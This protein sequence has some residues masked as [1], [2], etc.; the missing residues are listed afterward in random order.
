MRYLFLI[1]VL[2][3]TL[4]A[5]GPP[6]PVVHLAGFVSDPAGTTHRGVWWNDGTPILLEMPEHITKT[7][8]IGIHASNGTILISGSASDERYGTGS[9]YPIVWENGKATILPILPGHENEAGIAMGAVI[10]GGSR[11]T[12][13]VVGN[14][15]VGIPVYWNGASLNILPFQ[16]QHGAG[17]KAIYDTPETMYAAGFTFTDS[18]IAKPC[19]WRVSDSTDMAGPEV[20]DSD[21]D[22]DT[23]VLAL[24]VDE[25]GVVYAAGVQYDED[26]REPVYWV[27]GKRIV[28]PGVTGELSGITVAGGQVIVTG[29]E[30][31]EDV[32]EFI[33]V[34]WVDGNRVDLPRSDN[35]NMGL[36]RGLYNYQGMVVVAGEEGSPRSSNDDW[37]RP[38]LWVGTERFE[39]GNTTGFAIAEPDAGIVV[40][41]AAEARRT[42]LL[43]RR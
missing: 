25:N 7:F 37:A 19:V 4:L 40:V 31:I 15:G 30:N 2:A 42:K 10:H 9:R 12:F 27:D 35:N 18:A 34:M 41:P 3:A 28:L 11:F 36:T 21:P 16:T 23:F 14:N 43:V 32:V 8:P 29:Y 26:V 22:L 39:V 17:I 24:H 38:V 20:L 13:G 1:L 5:Q 33:P 6:S